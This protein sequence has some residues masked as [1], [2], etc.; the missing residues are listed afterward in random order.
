MEHFLLFP[1]VMS[2]GHTTV[3]VDSAH[4]ETGRLRAYTNVERD[5]HGIYPVCRF[6]F[7]RW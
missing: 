5:G 2:G 1:S 7:W 4:A 6:D 3:V